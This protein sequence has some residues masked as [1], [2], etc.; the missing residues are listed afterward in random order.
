LR[1]LR[2]KE[3]GKPLVLEDV[4][5]PTPGYGQVLVRL[6]VT[7]VCHT[8]LHQW[9]GDW[10]AMAEIM[11]QSNVSILGHEGIGVVE[12]V[13]PGV[14]RLKKGDR[15]GIP[16]M[17][18]WCGFCEACLSG[19]PH[20]CFNAKY[21]SAHIDGTYAEYVLIHEV[22][23]PIIPKEISDE[24]AAPMMCGGITAYGAVRKLITE[25]RIPSGKPIA[26]I[27]AAG[28]L[29]HNAVQIAK[30]FGYKVV[31]VDIGKER[32]DFV[33]KLG[34][35]YA[36][37]VG[38]AEKFIRERLGG[39][40]ASLVFAPKIKAFELGLK[41]LRPLGVLVTIGAP[42]ES[43]GPIPVTPI[44]MLVSG[45]KIIPSI[46]GVTHE[47]EEL[48]RL[49]SEG[50]VRSYVSRTTALN[51]RDVMELYEDLERGKY[52]GRAVIKISY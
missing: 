39:V 15:V 37:E 28:G 35:D 5:K 31:G 2:I 29:G 43:E 7:G 21:T 27:G 13:G 20:W 30:A 11:R 34:A 14:S 18:Y 42:A 1:A 45:I 4:P 6:S 36:L 10:P 49:A 8:D 41:V 44:G 19:Y 40:Y 51:P 12:E 9:R 33:E 23:A 50:K 25:A 38:E 46:V 3:F 16:W 48:F 24:Q 32:V 17:N 22:A 26:V 52:M 47:F